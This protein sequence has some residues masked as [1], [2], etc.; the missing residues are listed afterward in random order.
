MDFLDPLP[1]NA[2]KKWKKQEKKRIQKEINQNLQLLKLHA[3]LRKKVGL[4]Q[5]EYNYKETAAVTNS[6]EKKK[7][8][9]I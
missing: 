7:S 9:E 8:S 3:A 2:P 5:P 6:N 4:M 1:N